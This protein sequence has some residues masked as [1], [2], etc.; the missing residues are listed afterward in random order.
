MSPTVPSRRF[1][2][3]DIGT[4][5]CRM[6]V[7]DVDDTGVLHELVREYAIANL[8]EGVDATHRLKPEA[9]ER[10]ATIIERYLS[11]L[12][13]LP[14]AQTHPAR[15]VALATSASRDAE[16]ADEF[17]RRLA[18]L[19]IFLQ[20]IPGEEEA[21]L[22]FAGAASAFPHEDVVVVDVGGGSTE[23]IAGR[24][25]EPP[26]FIH[27]FN[28]GCRRVTERFL[29][30]DPPTT[31]E[32]ET[33]RCWI[34]EQTA[35]LLEGLRAQNAAGVLARAAA[36]P[37]DSPSVAVARMPRMVAV[38]GTATSVVSMREGMEVYDRA[39]VHKANVTRAQ[40]AEITSALA[41]V[42]LDRRRQT[43]GLDPDRAPVIVAGLLVLAEVMALLGADSFTVS[44]SDI[45]QGMVLRAALE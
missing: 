24:S 2:V 15:I 9:I 30:S 20:V 1:A 28:V 32:L 25:G 21:S 37:D 7:A 45:L 3:I 8:G 43:V 16:N 6:L 41:A 19:G 40:L 39:R 44:E 36:C 5:T 17:E 29:H 12:G 23:V 18:E 26:S 35:P 22:S 34:R 38:A 4:V 13:E 14:E 42:P 10:V 31:D 11:I 27:S 33:A